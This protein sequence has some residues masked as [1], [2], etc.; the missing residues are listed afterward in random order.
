MVICLGHLL[1]SE[2]FREQSKGAALLV[3]TSGGWNLMI[4]EVPSNPSHSVIL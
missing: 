2:L 1:T 3:G 4:P